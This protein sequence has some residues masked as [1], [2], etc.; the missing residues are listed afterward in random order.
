MKAGVP[1]GANPRLLLTACEE[2]RV[3]GVGRAPR[4]EPT[5]LRMGQFAA[6]SV[7]ECPVGAGVVPG[8]EHE[9]CSLVL[10]S[11]DGVRV[12]VSRVSLDGEGTS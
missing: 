1:G 5:W 9:L 4:A 12:D 3:L 8:L 10:R 6:V 7:P 2:E 11:A